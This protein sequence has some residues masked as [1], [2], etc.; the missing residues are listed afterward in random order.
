MALI[1]YQMPY[2]VSHLTYS[3]VKSAHMC[4]RNPG[5]HLKLTIAYDAHF[6]RQHLEETNKLFFPVAKKG[7]IRHHNHCRL[8]T[9]GYQIEGDDCLPTL[10]TTNQSTMISGRHF[11]IGQLLI[12]FQHAV[13]LELNRFKLPLSVNQSV[14]E[15]KT[16]AEIE[17]LIKKP[18]WH[19]IIASLFIQAVNLGRYAT[20]PLPATLTK[21]IFGINKNKPFSELLFKHGR[22]GS[23]GYSDPL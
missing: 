18:P 23:G 20:Q 5:A 19:E 4:H 13:E 14:V 7:N 12:V 22:Q 3:A 10:G 15:T 21:F 11:F 9:L 6:L 2:F 1:H 8:L 16:L 17:Q